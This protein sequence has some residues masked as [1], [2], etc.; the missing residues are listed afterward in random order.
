VSIGNLTKLSAAQLAQRRRFAAWMQTLPKPLWMRDAMLQM[1]WFA[2]GNQYPAFLIDYQFNAD[3]WSAHI[4][5]GDGIGEWVR[6][7]H[8]ACLLLRPVDAWL[9]K[10]AGDAGYVEAPVPD[11]FDPL[12]TEYGIDRAAPRL[13][14]RPTAR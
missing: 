4:F 7:R 13:F 8:F 11:G 14:L 10:I 6:R 5:V 1:P 2:T 3:A 9:I 12:A